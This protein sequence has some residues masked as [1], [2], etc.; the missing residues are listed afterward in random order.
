MPRKDYEEFVSQRKDS[1]FML[2]MNLDSF[3]LRNVE[4]HTAAEKFNQ[5][6]TDENDEALSRAL[7]ARDES[8]E[9]IVRNLETLFGISYSIQRD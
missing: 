4:Y 6:E 8:T 1:I 2:S 7:E 3:I 5:D 9:A